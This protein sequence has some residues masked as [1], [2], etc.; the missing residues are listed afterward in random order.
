MKGKR[1]IPIGAALIILGFA[2]LEHVGRYRVERHYQEALAGRRQLELEVGEMFATH[3][4]LTNDLAQERQRTQE[5]SEA[6]AS[7][8]GQVEEAVGRLADERRTVRELQ[9]HLATMQGQMDQLQ[10]ELAL[11]LQNQPAGGEQ[12]RATGPVQLERIIVSDALAGGPLQGRV[13]SVHQDWN[14][15]VIDLGWNAVKIGDTVSIFRQ[16]HLLA[17]ARVERVQESICAATVLPQWSA[18]DI[19]PN[20][21]VKTL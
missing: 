14:F 19:Q 10:A 1:W 6:L 7:T 21:V 18:T 4:Q 3:K 5:L 16:D 9:T 20:D 2:G 8:R 13:L 17:K 12:P 11:T 15:V